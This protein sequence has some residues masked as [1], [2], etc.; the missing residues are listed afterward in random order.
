MAN[1]IQAGSA[2]VDTDGAIFTT[3]VK[4]AYILFTPDAANDSLLLYD[5]ASTTSNLKITIKGA[6]AKHTVYFD[7]SSAPIVFQNGIYV[8]IATN[9][10]AVLV[11]TNKGES[12]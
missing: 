8:D 12:I 5:S 7:F 11:L 6:T 2:H 10:T 9:G 1:V 3:R 4:L